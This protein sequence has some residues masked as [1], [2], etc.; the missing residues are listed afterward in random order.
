VVNKNI[1]FLLSFYKDKI[2]HVRSHIEKNN[3][4]SLTYKDN[5]ARFIR[6]ET[7]ETNE[8]YF[9]DHGFK[10]FDKYKN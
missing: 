3:I 10:L 9:V 6:K 4:T 8:I 1:S 7:K 5:D 2:S